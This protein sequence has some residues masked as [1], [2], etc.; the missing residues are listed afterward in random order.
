MIT[1]TQTLCF[2]L[3][4]FYFQSCILSQNPVFLIEPLRRKLRAS[5]STA[6]GDSHCLSGNGKS[7]DGYIYSLDKFSNN[8]PIFRSTIY[9]YFL[10]YFQFLNLT[11]V[12]GAKQL[13]SYWLL[14]WEIFAKWRK[15]KFKSHWSIHL[16]FPEIVFL[17]YYNALTNNLCPSELIPFILMLSS[18]SYQP[19][20]LFTDF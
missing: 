6:E 10:R 17:I 13:N 9:V 5:A 1:L 7:G 19:K 3:S 12:L 11:K 18:H 14:A 16:P 8:L 15:S 4:H 20:D 2:Y